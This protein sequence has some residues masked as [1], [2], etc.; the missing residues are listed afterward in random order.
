V[1]SCRNRSVIFD[2]GHGNISLEKNDEKIEDLIENI[3]ELNQSPQRNEL[4][5]KSGE[6]QIDNKSLQSSIEPKN[7]S[8]LEC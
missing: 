8:D 7:E 4:N 2:L 5:T 3:V 6:V 1:L